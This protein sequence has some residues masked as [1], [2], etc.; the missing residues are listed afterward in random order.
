MKLVLRVEDGTPVIFVKEG[1]T[2][3]EVDNS[4]QSIIPVETE[5]EA[6]YLR[7]MFPGIKAEKNQHFA[8]ILLED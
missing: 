1:N 3:H 2:L 4:Q 8:L 6:T 7:I 5:A